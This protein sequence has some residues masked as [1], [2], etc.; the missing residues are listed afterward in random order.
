VADRTVVYLDKAG[1]WRW[2]RVAPNGEIIASSGESFTRLSDAE[3]AASRAFMGPDGSP[4]VEHGG[5]EG[6]V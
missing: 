1:E 6:D 4:E 2:R 3:R 5:G